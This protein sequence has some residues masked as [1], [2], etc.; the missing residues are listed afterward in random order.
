M[1]FDAAMRSASLM[2]AVKWGLQAAVALLPYSS[3]VVTHAYA[4]KQDDKID[5]SELIR[6]HE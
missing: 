3:N 6:L 5:F 2:A 4:L 1:D